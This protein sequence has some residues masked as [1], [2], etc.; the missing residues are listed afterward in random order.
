MYMW[1]RPRRAAGSQPALLT[2]TDNDRAFLEAVSRLAYCNPFLPQQRVALGDAFQE[3]EPVIESPCRQI[4]ASER[5]SIPSLS[6]GNPFLPE[7]IAY[8]RAAL[9]DDFQEGEPGIENLCQQIAARETFSIP[10]L[11][12]C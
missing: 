3:G 2:M 11:S 7:R 10:S 9:G 5:F 12:A 8:E 4:A 1:G 6:A